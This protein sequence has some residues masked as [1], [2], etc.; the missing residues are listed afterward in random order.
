MAD[1]SQSPIPFPTTLD[2]DADGYPSDER[3]D[4]IRRATD[5]PTANIRQFRNIDGASTR[6]HGLW[7]KV[8]G[9]GLWT[10]AWLEK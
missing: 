6:L 3:I 8:Q 2:V 4:Q 1:Q 7:G 10:E 9:T 5:I